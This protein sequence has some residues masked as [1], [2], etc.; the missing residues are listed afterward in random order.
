[1]VTL[2]AERGGNAT[3][4]AYRSNTGTVQP[5]GILRRS[6]I[7]CRSRS[8]AAGRRTLIGRAVDA[9]RTGILQT[10]AP[11]WDQQSRAGSF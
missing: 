4:H 1:M 7:D 9:H 11:S 10:S 5:I 3:A 6:G 8:R 2:V